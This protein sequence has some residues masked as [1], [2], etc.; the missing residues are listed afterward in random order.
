[1]IYWLK[2]YDGN[3]IH[4]KGIKYFVVFS[5]HVINCSFMV[6]RQ[7]KICEH[8]TIDHFPLYRLSMCSMS[9]WNLSS[10]LFNTELRFLGKKTNY[11]SKKWMLRDM[12][13]FRA[14]L[15]VRTWI[16]SWWFVFPR[17]YDKLLQTCSFFFFIQPHIKSCVFHKF[18]HLWF[19][20]D[21]FFQFCFAD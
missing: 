21:N 4:K 11:E 5:F 20:K 18:S 17:N 14:L 3:N 2:I 12:L 9:Q 6:N 13:H 7:I 8:Y 15:A 19:Y 10:C 1:M 16:I